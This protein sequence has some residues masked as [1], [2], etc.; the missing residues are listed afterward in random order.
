MMRQ[1]GSPEHLE[2][3]ASYHQV[4]LAP[5]N[6]T[7]I[8]D[9]RDIGPVLGVVDECT[10]LILFTGCTDGIVHLT[11]SLEDVPPLADDSWEV[12]ESVSITIDTPLYIWSPTGAFTRRADG[13][14][15]FLEPKKTGPHRVRVSA[16]GR[17]E[18]NA[19]Y[20][21]TSPEHFLIQIWPETSLHLRET[22]RD[23]GF[24]MGA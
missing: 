10:A 21:L 1:T 18:D 6:T 7:P 22:L 13:S 17:G 3:E 2:A 4:F 15:W 8:Y 9:G 23:D 24:G 19:E 16:R 12:Q 11:I 14:P 5:L 20:T